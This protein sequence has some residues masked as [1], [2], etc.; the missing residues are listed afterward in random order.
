[1]MMTTGVM[2]ETAGTGTDIDV[3]SEAFSV[4]L[5]TPGRDYAQCGPLCH[6]LARRPEP[7]TS[8]EEVNAE[9]YSDFK[10]SAI[11][12]CSSSVSAGTMC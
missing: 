7:V 4:T 11:A 9:C 10:Y 8:L 1:M 12:V 5:M 3:R 2:T 6:S